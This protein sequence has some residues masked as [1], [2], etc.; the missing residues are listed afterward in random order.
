MLSLVTSSLSGIYAWPQPL[1]GFGRKRLSRHHGLHQP[2]VGW[3]FTA[4]LVMLFTR[5]LPR[6]A[7]GYA[8][9]LL[10]ASH[11]LTAFSPALAAL[12]SLVDYPPLSESHLLEV[13]S[14]MGHR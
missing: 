2:V 10:D 12:L 4:L 6:P 13:G 14:P 11:G 3:A 1:F 8:L 9:G 7:R 5:V